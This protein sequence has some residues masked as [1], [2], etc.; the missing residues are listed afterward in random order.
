MKITK[1]KDQIIVDVKVKSRKLATDPY[2]VI[3]LGDVLTFLK[4]EGIDV[5]KDY[6]C[7]KQIVVGNHA[8]NLPLAGQFVFCKKKDLTLPVKNDTVE[9]V[10]EEVVP[11]PEPKVVSTKPATTSRRRRR[12]RGA[13]T[14]EENKLLGTKTME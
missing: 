2:E 11:S 10:K 3:D 13:R 1:N 6:I 5:S 8:E 4:S 9:E 14:K 12:T 7:E